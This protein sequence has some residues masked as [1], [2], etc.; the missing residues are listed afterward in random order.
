LNTSK[1]SSRESPGVETAPAD[2]ILLRGEGARRFLY[3]WTQP[4]A[5]LVSSIKEVGILKPLVLSSSGVL[6]SGVRRLLA[7]KEAG[8]REVPVLRADDSKRAFLDGLWENIGHR[9]FTLLE[10]SEILIRL[11]KA[12]GIE[13]EKIVRIF[14]PALGLAPSEL[15][16]EKYSRVARL[17]EG[18]KETAARGRLKDGHLLLLSGLA[19]EDAEALAGLFARLSPSAGEARDLKG[20][21][22]AWALREK[23]SLAEAIAREEIEETADG[24]KPPRL[25]VAEL[26]RRLRRLVLPELSRL[27][28]EA[29]RAASEAALTGLRL[30]SDLGAGAFELTVR[31]RRLSDFAKAVRNLAS[32]KALRA[33]ER[34]LALLRGERIK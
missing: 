23:L 13:R 10:K 19:P 17:G 31:V 21:L 28:E 26:R 14:M 18:I 34:I 20:L 6:I 33:A 22:E 4:P 9:D 24:E 8:L 25:R 29:H 2:S 27:E 11:E 12:A 7:A 15:L 16:L 1:R 3:T 5:G 32:E 30:P